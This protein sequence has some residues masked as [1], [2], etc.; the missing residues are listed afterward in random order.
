MATQ[1]K[2]ATRKGQKN[3]KSTKRTYRAKPKFINF[4]KDNMDFYLNGGKATPASIERF[5]DQMLEFFMNNKHEKRLPKYRIL[6][7]VS[8]ELYY[9][10]KKK[11]DYLKRRDELCREI[12][13]QRREEALEVHDPATLKTT[14]PL[15]SREWEQ[16]LDESAKRNAK[17]PIPDTNLNVYLEDF[18]QLTKRKKEQEH[19]E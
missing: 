12:L 13:G 5:A 15:Y 16:A 11:S 14:L 9:Q 8:N 6:R 1:T 2:N 7:G 17:N 3:N 10:W 19:E 18:E 4:K